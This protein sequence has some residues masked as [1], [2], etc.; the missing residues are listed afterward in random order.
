MRVKTSPIIAIGWNINCVHEQIM[1]QMFISVCTSAE[2]FVS[3]ILKEFK[4]LWSLHEKASESALKL[5]TLSAAIS[6]TET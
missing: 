6:K 3:Y 2:P 4:V 1:S 5:L